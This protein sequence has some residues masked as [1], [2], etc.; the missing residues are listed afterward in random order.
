MDPSGLYLFLASRLIAID[1]LPGVR[2]IGVGEVVR[3][4]VGKVVLT[5]LNQ[6]IL[7]T[8]GFSQLCAAQPGGCEAPVHAVRSLFDVSSGEAVL[9]VDAS[10]AFNSLNR[11]TAL[12]NCLISCPTLA[13]VLINCYRFHSPL[14]VDSEVLLS[15]E[16]TTQGD[17]LAMAM[18]AIGVLP[19]IHHLNYISVSQ[20]WYADDAAGVGYLS[21]LRCWWYELSNIGPAY[22]Y[23]SNPLKS[24]LIVKPEFLDSAQVL[25][26]DI[27]INITSEGHRYLG[28]ALGSRDFVINFTKEKVSEWVEQIDRLVQVARTQPHVAYSALVHGFFNKWVYLFRTTPDLT[29]YV[30]PLEDCLR[31]RLIPTLTGQTSVSNTIRSLL[32]LPARLGGLGIFDPTHMAESQYQNSVY[33]LTPLISSLCSQ[34][35]SVPMSS[36]LDISVQEKEKSDLI[37]IIIQKISL[38]ILK[39]L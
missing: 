34:D 4:L 37:T 39:P 12:H 14:F 17:P 24:W 9:L 5:I 16:G 2:P 19:L 33:I 8:T 31:L 6:D 30:E 26:S 27:D 35:S 20:I 1:K 3:R 18:Y 38:P 10:N 28:S 13:T 7:E 29:S 32:S 25:F 21:S 23:Y 11:E 36:I 15:S 22:G